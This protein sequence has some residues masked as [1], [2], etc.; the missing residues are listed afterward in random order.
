MEKHWTDIK[1]NEFIDAYNKYPPNW[2]IRTVFKYFSKGNETKKNMKVSNIFTGILLGLFS[3]GI[4][5]T[6]L[7]WSDKLI[8]IFTIIY[9]IILPLLV[10]FIFIGVWMN[11]KRIKK[12]AKSLNLTIREYNLISRRYL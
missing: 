1:Y 2:W 3:L 7:N 4:L 6:I 11:N 10:I 5:G 9:S 8:G 12:I